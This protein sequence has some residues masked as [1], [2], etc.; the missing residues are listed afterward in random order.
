MN[1]PHQSRGRHNIFSKVDHDKQFVKANYVAP[2]TSPSRKQNVSIDIRKKL[3]VQHLSSKLQQRTPVQTVANCMEGEVIDEPP[4]DIHLQR[5]Q[6]SRRSRAPPGADGGEGA[7]AAGGAAGDAAAA[8]AAE[9]EE[10][11]DDGD[12]LSV[13]SNHS[14]RLE[15]LKKS[16][17]KVEKIASFM[18]ELATGAVGAD[19]KPVESDFDHLLGGC[20]AVNMDD[21]SDDDNS[22]GDDDE[23]SFSEVEDARKSRR[24]FSSA[25]EVHH[26][27]M[28]RAERKQAMKKVQSV[29]SIK[30]I[31]KN[32][33]T[34]TAD[35][36][37]G[38]GLLSR[39]T[40]RRAPTGFE[41]VESSQLVVEEDNSTVNVGG[42][43]LRKG[44]SFMFL[45]S[46]AASPSAKDHAMRTSVRSNFSFGLSSMKSSGAVDARCSNS[47]SRGLPSPQRQ[48][49]IK[50]PSLWDTASTKNGL[51]DDTSTVGLP[52]AG[53]QQYNASSGGFQYSGTASS[54]LNDDPLA[55]RA[56][57]ESPQKQYE[58]MFISQRKLPLFRGV[59]TK[60]AQVVDNSLSVKT[61]AAL[62]T[63]KGISLKNSA[64]SGKN[65]LSDTTKLAP[66]A[67]AI[68]LVVG[69][70]G[71]SSSSPS[72]YFVPSLQSVHERERPIMQAVDKAV[73][74]LSFQAAEERPA[75]QARAAEALDARSLFPGQLLR[76]AVPQREAVP[77][78]VLNAMLNALAA[79]PHNPNASVYGQAI[80]PPKPKR[81]ATAQIFD[82]LETARQQLQREEQKKHLHGAAFGADQVC[83]SRVSSPMQQQQQQQ[84]GASDAQS[85]CSYATF[86]TPAHLHAPM[87]RLSPPLD[88]SDLATGTGTGL[89]PAGA[90]AGAAPGSSTAQESAHAKENFAVGGRDD[91]SSYNIAVHR[92]KL[93]DIH[94]PQ[95]QSPYSNAHSK[96][97]LNRYPHG[98]PQQASPILVRNDSQSKEHAKGFHGALA[99]ST[100]SYLADVLLADDHAKLHTNPQKY[101]TYSPPAAAAA[102]VGVGVG[103]SS[104][105][106][107][108]Q[109]EEEF[110]NLDDDDEACA[111]AERTAA[112]AVA[113][114]KRH[115]QHPKFSSDVNTDP[116]RDTSVDDFLHLHLQPKNG[117][118]SNAEEMLRQGFK[119]QYS[120]NS[121]TA[122]REVNSSQ[123]GAY[124]RPQRAPFGDPIAA[125]DVV[126]DLAAP[127]SGRHLR[128]IAETT[129]GYGPPVIYIPQ[130]KPAAEPPAGV[131]R[132]T[133]V[134]GASSST[135][136]VSYSS[137][138]GAAGGAGAAAM[139]HGASFS[140]A[141]TLSSGMGGS[142]E[143]HSG[144]K[145]HALS[146]LA[147]GQV[148]ADRDYSSARS[149]MQHPS[150]DRPHAVHYSYGASGGGSSAAATPLKPTGDPHSGMRS[151][152]VSALGFTTDEDGDERTVNRS[153]APEAF[154]IKSHINAYIDRITPSKS[155]TGLATPFSSFY[156]G[157]ADDAASMRSGQST[158]QTSATSDEARTKLWS[159]L[160][161]RYTTDPEHKFNVGM[162]MKHWVYGGIQ[163]E[164]QVM[165]EYME[166]MDED[167]VMP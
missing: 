148:I 3:A 112:E 37:V 130:G 103:G 126:A 105:A 160:H 138:A 106:T 85:E 70:S 25:L 161:G 154:D 88:L 77:D 81:N 115:Q 111:D 83:G 134:R 124:E 135:H 147:P 133:A 107:R 18:D 97:I 44:S 140:S 141:L 36:A 73:H 79:D 123:Y 149:V 101:Q 13:A 27:F 118:G 120:T 113:D 76:A 50:G 109:L 91:A 20:G 137:G 62:S 48:Q 152:Q 75:S 156:N 51:N 6:Y 69:S 159:K 32:H 98:Q 90:G 155:G 153:I 55:Q 157:P 71:N 30:A 129:A 96:Y 100:Q 139:P 116:Q 99:K 11:D 1:S 46:I 146:A 117:P 102:A 108:E 66:S 45:S 164:T 4:D 9:E 82:Q 61:L 12:A 29:G 17:Q 16:P 143:V 64:V 72:K 24:I 14:E 93:P 125:G 165:R 145:H 131:S 34:L 35:L 132:N 74:L 163:E 142:A 63:A 136:D 21:D 33:S 7:G 68:D 122:A 47:S 127:F 40:S 94:S 31:T 59:S 78:A 22:D 128:A 67:K 95:Q 119:Y 86:N 162:K 39:N 49:S 53:K 167:W 5:L 19:G 10:E 151:R 80:V 15:R 87:P 54:L 92:L 110:F 26:S 56:R 144:V 42:S 158:V 114:S 28:R 58:D 60:K 166:E 121:Y 2:Q 23:D 65:N 57:S 41:A 43:S 89:T 38:T 52:S 8:D 104:V 84:R 150:E